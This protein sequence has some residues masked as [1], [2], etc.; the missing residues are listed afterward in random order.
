MLFHHILF[1]FKFIDSKGMG[2]IRCM[3]MLLMSLQMCTKLNQYYHVYH[4]MVE[5]NVY[6]FKDI[7]NTN[8]FICQEMFVQIW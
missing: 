5:Q 1:V 3:V 6:F 4:M 7:L 8:H 2:N